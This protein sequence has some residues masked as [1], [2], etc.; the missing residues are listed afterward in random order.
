MLSTMSARRNQH[1]SSCTLGH[2]IP[3]TCHLMVCS[4]VGRFVGEEVNLVRSYRRH[5]LN[6]PRQADIQ[7]DR[8]GKW[9]KE[10]PSVAG[11]Q[12]LWDRSM[13]FAFYDDNNK[14]E[15]C[16]H[17][18]DVDDIYYSFILLL[19]QTVVDVPLFSRFL[20][21]GNKFF[22][23]RFVV[24]K[25]VTLLIDDEATGDVHHVTNRWVV[26]NERILSRMHL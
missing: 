14:C 13:K 11:L 20:L 8:H 1:L 7:T 17:L 9:C 22:I 25:S 3:S 4:V 2:T 19:L 26:W 5:A 24:Y 23:D 12:L 15:R 6:W 16:Y 10:V 18:Q 21:L